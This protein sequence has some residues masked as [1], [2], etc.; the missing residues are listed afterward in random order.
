[1]ARTQANYLYAIASVALVLYV[2]GFFGLMA[3]HGQKLVSFFKEKVDLW[4]ELKPGLSEAE[5][6]RLVAE[7]R[8]NPMVKK[9]SVTFITREQAA[10]TMREDLGE[11]SMLEDMPDLLRDVVRFN[12]KAEY[13]DDKRLLEW[14]E[15]LRQDTLVSDLYFEAANT[16]N[17]GQNIQSLGLIGLILGI[18][19][20]IASTILIHNT[21]RLAMYS[22]RFIIKNQELVG[23]S[24]EFI[25]RPFIRKGILNGLWSA[26]LAILAL[27]LTLWWLNRIMPELAQLQDLN[28]VVLVFSGLALL[29]VL[30]SG[31]STKWVVNKFLRMKL[32][33][34]Y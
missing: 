4:M 8:Q 32:D 2:L 13:L 25:S 11:E 31:L 10:A 24:W 16:N 22:N 1:M 9:E 12:V 5:I 7:V 15:T 28:A 27:S 3:L 30:I 23:A 18:L 20:I 6:G 19:L 26:L 21:I 17:V 33:D 14:R 29:G 34:L